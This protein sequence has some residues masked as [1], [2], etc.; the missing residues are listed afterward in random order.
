[1]PS[2]SVSDARQYFSSNN[3]NVI[4]SAFPPT[5][6]ATNTIWSIRPFDETTT[7]LLGALLPPAVLT[8]DWPEITNW[9]PGKLLLF[10]VKGTFIPFELAEKSVLSPLSNPPHLNSTP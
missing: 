4:L 9:P 5:L 6:P 7:L 1:M 8:T 2:P 3:C 10:T